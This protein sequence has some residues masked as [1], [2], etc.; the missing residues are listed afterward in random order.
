MKITLSNKQKV[1]QFSS[2]LKNLKNFSNDIEIHISP[3][4]MFAQVMDNSHACLFE[5]HLDAEWFETY[6]VEQEVVLGINCELLSRVLNC[7]DANQKIEIKYEEDSDNLFITLFPNEGE[8]GI[9]KEFK[10]PLIDIETDI[11]DVPDAEFTADI[12]MLSQEFSELVSQLSIFG[13]DLQIRCKD[14]IRVT[15]KGELGSMDAIIKEDDIIMFAIEEDKELSLLY[16]M[17]Y[18]LLI[19]S[20]SKVNKKVQIHISEEI[21][22]KIQY[23]MDS[24]MDENDDN[25]EESEGDKNFIR[26]FL[27]PK[28]ED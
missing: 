5:L 2:I 16:A 8:S 26:F 9:I 4:K 12:E 22:M 17:S 14:D 27:A 23:S 15:G 19:T 21:P 18:V 10:M 13:Q 7:L 24:F 25:D 28:I 6:E 11:L 20:F 1:S 3:S